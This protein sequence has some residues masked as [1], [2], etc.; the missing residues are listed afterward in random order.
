MASI[1]ALLALCGVFLLALFPNSMLLPPTAL[2]PEKVALVFLAL[3]FGVALIPKLQ[4][5]LLEDRDAATFA[6]MAAFFV[7]YHLAER[8]G[9][10]SG[11]TIPSELFS[12]EVSVTYALRL[13]FIG[14]LAS[15]PVWWKG[16]GPQ[17]NLLA[18]SILIGVL[19]LGSF[20]FLGRFYPVGATETVD[21]TPLPTLLLQLL[22]YGCVAAL[23]RAVTA[24]PAYTKTLLRL[25]PVFLLVLAAKYQIFPTVQPE[26]DAE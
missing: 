11:F 16:G 7:V 3:S 9:P 18:A 8:A 23:C 14:A 13:V 24:S 1:F 5:K 4:K 17:R 26:E 10:R 19:G 15:I 12:D 21:P 22:G 2:L 20:W 6:L 25:M